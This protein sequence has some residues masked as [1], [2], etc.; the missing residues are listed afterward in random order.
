[1]TPDGT[2][3]PVDLQGCRSSYERMSLDCCVVQ[4]AYWG[5]VRPGSSTPPL[6]GCLIQCQ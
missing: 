1:M 3:L 6:R 4:D 5:T 2:A